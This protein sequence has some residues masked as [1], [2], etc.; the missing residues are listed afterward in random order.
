MGPPG[1][2]P[3]DALSARSGGHQVAP[4]GACTGRYAARDRPV[5]WSP[6]VLGLKTS[7]KPG[8]G[9]KE[10][11]RGSTVGRVTMDQVRKIAEQKI[12]DINAFDLDH[13]ARI[14][15]GTARSMGITVEG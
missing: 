7:K 4:W 13:G 6:P 12:K 1:L 10:P 11:G 14:I 15:A 2:T 9:S 3:S 8:A 5:G